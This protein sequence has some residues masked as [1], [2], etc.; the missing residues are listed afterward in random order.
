MLTL[1]NMLRPITAASLFLTSHTMEW[2]VI[3]PVGIAV[4]LFIALRHPTEGETR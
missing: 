1:L 2:F 4:G 3:P